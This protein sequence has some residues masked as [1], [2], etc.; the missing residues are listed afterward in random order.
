[1]TV[2]DG[3]FLARRRPADTFEIVQLVRGAFQL[4]EGPIDRTTAKT[5]VVALAAAVGAQAWIEDVIGYPCPLDT[6]KP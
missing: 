6:P 3:D 4:I 5:R 2:E 1:M